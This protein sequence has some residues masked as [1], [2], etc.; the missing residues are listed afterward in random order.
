MLNAISKTASHIDNELRTAVGIRRRRRVV[1]RRH[2]VRDVFLVITRGAQFG[3]ATQ[4]ANKDELRDIR[5]RGSRRREG[6]D[7]CLN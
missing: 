3:V 2:S 4:A 7:W 5:A 1:G 6:L